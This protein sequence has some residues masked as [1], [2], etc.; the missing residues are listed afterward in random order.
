MRDLL[1]LAN[2]A[3]AEALIGVGFRYEDGRQVQD[4]DIDAFWDDMKSTPNTKGTGMATISALL[5]NIITCDKATK[6][7]SMEEK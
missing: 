6:F 5:M 2:C 7:I 3:S 4:F 1:S